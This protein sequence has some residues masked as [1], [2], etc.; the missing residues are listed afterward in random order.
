MATPEFILAL[1]EHVGTMPLWLAGATA[2]VHRESATGT[3][4]LLAR[5]ADSGEW[6]PVSGIIDPGEHPADAAVREVAEETGVVV[7]VERLVWVDVTDEV[8][9][10]NGDR[11]QYINHTFRCRYVV[12]EPHPRDGENLEV[13]FFAEDALPPLANRHA[14][15]LRAAIADVPEC[16]LGPLP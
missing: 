1:R 14:A 8:T 6:A 15:P 7:E 11:S 12:G 3:H 13:A 16:G 9:Y 10:S 4:W 2:C 5:R